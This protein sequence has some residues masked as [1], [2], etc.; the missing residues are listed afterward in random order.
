MLSISCQIEVSASLRVYFFRNALSMGINSFCVPCST[1]DSTFF[2]LDKPVDKQMSS[3]VGGGFLF[4][5]LLF[6]ARS[7]NILF[8]NIDCVLF[9]WNFF[10]VPNIFIAVMLDLNYW[11]IVHYVVVQDMV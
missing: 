10:I 2:L 7:G 5:L 3:F 11:L 1:K 4:V 6:R 9:Y 8:I